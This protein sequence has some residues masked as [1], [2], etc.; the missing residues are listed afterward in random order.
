MA[1][2]MSLYTGLSHRGTQQ[3]ILITEYTEKD[4]NLSFTSNFIL[5]GRYQ[6]FRHPVLNVS[7]KFYQSNRFK[8]VNLHS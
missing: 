3:L 6:H 8:K 4:D 7:T 1:A 2:M 5:K